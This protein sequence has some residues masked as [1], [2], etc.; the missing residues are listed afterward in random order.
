MSKKIILL[1][2]YCGDINYKIINQYF[3]GNITV[4]NSE[5]EK[6]LMNGFL[7]NNFDVEMIAAPAVGKFPLTCKKN[8]ITGFKEQDKIHIV[9]YFSFFPFIFN[10]K[11]KALKHKIS[12][13]IDDLN[14]NDEIVVIAC[15]PHLPYLRT[16]KYVKNKYGFKTSLIVPDLPEDIKGSNSIF[17]KAVKTKQINEIY[18]LSNQYADSYLFFTKQMINKFNIKNK[19][20]IVREGVIESFLSAKR[21]FNDKKIC[22]YIGKTNEQNGIDLILKL[23]GDKK[24]IEF[25][26]YGNGDME[27]QIINSNLPNIKY[28]GFLNPINVNEKLLLSDIL[29]SPRYSRNYTNFS[30]PS[31]I[32]KYIATGKP[33]V[34]FK[35]PCY[36]D[37]FNKILYFPEKEDYESFKK[38]FESALSDSSKDNSENIRKYTNY[39]LSNNVAND[40][41]MILF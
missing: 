5:Y 16:L 21:I 39:L 38:A 13:L 18:S 41:S 25:R 34:T 3:K 6:A 40:F 23:A 24:E 26:I 28:F 33:I 35:L 8:Y 7:S 4:S 32:L 11:T 22:T 9:K 27:D 30:F 14:K 20:F 2:S 12:M 10:S 17:Y 29:V 15:E 1:G 36:P 37:D 31:K 19:Q